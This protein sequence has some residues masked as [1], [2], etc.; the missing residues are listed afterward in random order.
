MH[1]AKYQEYWQPR[2]IWH[3]LIRTLSYTDKS[4]LKK[5]EYAYTIFVQVISMIILKDIPEEVP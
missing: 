2:V 4:W 5:I 1:L 3:H